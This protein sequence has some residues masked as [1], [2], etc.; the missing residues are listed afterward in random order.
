M[1]MQHITAKK[2]LGQH[3]L[4]SKEAL[5]KIIAAAEIVPGETVLEIGPGEGVLTEALL[6]AGARV[7]AV[8]AD[9]RCVEKLKERF[10]DAM[11]T[12]KFLLIEGD[13]RDKKM[14]KELFTKKRTTTPRSGLSKPRPDLSPLGEKPY[15]LVA[16]IPYYITGML[17]R[18][19]LEKL[20]QPS[21]LVFLVQK[22]VAEQIVARPNPA[23]RDEQAGKESILSLAVKIFGTPRYVA[24]VRREAF[25]PPPKVD[26]AI[27]AVTDISRR[28]LGKLS[29]EAYFR[30]VKAGMGSKRKMLLGNLARARLRPTS[31]GQGLNIPKE[32]LTEIFGKL[33]I[34]EHVRGEDIPVEKWIALAIEVEKS[35]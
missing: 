27:I 15:K 22:E 11:K 5:G 3:F 23:K 13:I 20:R 25:A 31:D 14:Q 21:L 16:N 19:F 29:D 30:I 7:V 8:E 2:S 18:L 28:R 32:K 24:K 10:A 1:T 6:S 9:A 33:G 34:D 12:K 26:S 17:F 35:Q 4:R